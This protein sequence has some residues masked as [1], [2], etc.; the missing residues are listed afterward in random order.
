MS[1]PSL[2]AATSPTADTAILIDWLRDRDVPCPLCGY[3]LRH[4]TSPR[5]PECGQELCLAVTAVEPFLKA[6]ITLAA[7]AAASAGV[8][9]LMLVL[10][11]RVGWPG[12]DEPLLDISI[13]LFIAMI[14]VAGFIFYRRRKLLKLARSTQWTVAIIC[15][16]MF[17][18]ALTM[19]MVKLR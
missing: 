1:E 16:A 10:V 3:N 11:A 17:A 12:E 6:W 2:L 8:G 13:C 18:I 19:F 14:P 7:S 4:L 9:V 5:C 15:I